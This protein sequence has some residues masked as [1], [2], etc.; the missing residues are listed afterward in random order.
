M[1]NDKNNMWLALHCHFR[2]AGERFEALLASSKNNLVLQAVWTKKTG[3]LPMKELAKTFGIPD[4]WDFSFNLSRAYLRYVKQTQELDFNL[5]AEEYGNLTLSRAVKPETFYK[6]IFTFDYFKIE[7]TDLPLI[8]SQLKL[9]EGDGVALT[10]LNCMYQP[11]DKKQGKMEIKFTFCLQ[12]GG[13]KGILEFNFKKDLR[14]NLINSGSISN[15][16]ANGSP[17]S[18]GAIHW[19]TLNK[20]IAVFHFHK[21]GAAFTDGR[22]YLYI[23]AGMDVSCVGLELLELYTCIPLSSPKAVTFGLRGVALSL[24]APPLTISGG[25]YK[26]RYSSGGEAMT[27]YNGEVS[28][29]FKDISLMALGSYGKMSGTDKASLFIYLIFNKPLGGPACFF[30]TGLCAGLGIN[31]AIRLP[32]LKDVENFPLIQAARGNDPGARSVA[33]AA[34]ALSR[35]GQIIYPK[36]GE[37]FICAG[38]R[39]VTYGVLESVALLSVEFGQ[40]FEVS[41]LGVSEVSLPPKVTGATPIVYAKLNLKAVFCPDDGILKIE[42]AL[43]PDSYLFTKDCKLSGGFAFYSWFSGKYAGDFVL[44]IG[45]YS[46]GFSKGHYPSVDRLGIRWEIGSGLSLTGDAYFAL[47]SNGI[48]AG[49]HLSLLFQKGKLKAWCNVSADFWM[50][51]KPFHYY[52]RFSV[53]VGASYRLDIWF[54]HKTFSVELSASLELWGPEFTGCVH[55]KW[56]IISFSIEFGHGTSRSPNPIGWDEF[57]STFFVDG[58]EKNKT[59]Y[60]KEMAEQTEY[61]PF[62]IVSGAL[63]SKDKELN[64]VSGRDLCFTINGKLPCHCIVYNGDT[65][66]VCKDK[67]GIVPMKVSEYQITLKVCV[68]PK[69]QE[70]KYAP[71]KAE[72]IR[73]NL[74]KALWGAE[75]PNS[76]DDMLMDVPVGLR[77]TAGGKLGHMLP[78]APEEWYDEK[79]LSE[80]EEIRRDGCFLWNPFTA[81]EGKDFRGKNSVE[82]ME[83]TLENCAVRKKYLSELSNYGSWQENEISLGGYRK[84]LRTILWSPVKLHTVAS[85]KWFEAQKGERMS[86]KYDE[87]EYA[88][89]RS[90]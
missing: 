13:N 65:L 86:I 43:S 87:R 3:A 2:L 21:I 35:L 72:I 15:Y 48:M 58:S 51:W 53:S 82:E 19:I 37:Y 11:S 74:P 41:L 67:F 56:F 8:G 59:A 77:L 64:L 89:W 28:V 33:N 62:S 85:E 20:D 52:G 36:A 47:I 46:P 81:P 29:S 16:A 80:N 49:G 55:I 71:L 84:N 39:F 5:D 22:I 24:S 23:S 26:D 76:S 83:R 27:L 7:L 70:S 38:I 12:L 79:T 25:L 68:Y 78:A 10:S 50:Q 69:G 17:P 75:A 31:R 30:V 4:F 1:G 63:T 44:S 54:I 6:L 73:S 57:E 66:E 14:Q 88:E 45:G 40:R 9:H 42:A 90:V 60:T 18:S 34:E 61:W 32:E